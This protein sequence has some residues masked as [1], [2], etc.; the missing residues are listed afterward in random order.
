MQDLLLARRLG[1]RLL[2]T[3]FPRECAACTAP[4]DDAPF[5]APCAR[6]VV[7]RARGCLRCDG[8]CEPGPD[9]SAEA[10][11]L[12]LRCRWA[13]PPFEVGYAVFD[14]LGPVGDAIRAGKYD[15]HPESLPAVADALVDLLPRSLRTDLPGVVVPV[16]LHPSRLA[17]R[18]VDAPGLLGR[19]VARALAVRLERGGLRRVRDTRP[20]AG[21]TGREREVNLDGAFF[22]HGRLEGADVLLVDDVMTTGATLRAAARALAEVGVGRVRVLAAAAVGLGPG[23]ER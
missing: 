5:C 6:G 10:V 17:R 20:Q 4:S 8:A 9:A 1:V 21:L 2:S 23:P 19:R 16:P 7:P 11:G 22:G 14:Y 13:P 18:P 3:L 15:A 12:C